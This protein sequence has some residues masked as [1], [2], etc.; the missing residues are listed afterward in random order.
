MREELKQ[1]SNLSEFQFVEYFL[2][3]VV[4]EIEN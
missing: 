2:A 1:I 4:V 3:W